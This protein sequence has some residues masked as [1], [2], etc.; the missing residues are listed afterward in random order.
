MQVSAKTGDGV[1]EMLR[2]MAEKVSEQHQRIGTGR[3]GAS[4]RKGSERTHLLSE[5]YDTDGK[6]FTTRDVSP[7][8]CPCCA[9]L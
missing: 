5:S 4:S 1:K 7:K 2:L 6:F 8:Y 3:S 9:I